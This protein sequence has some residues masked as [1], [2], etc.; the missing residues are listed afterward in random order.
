YDVIVEGERERQR[1]PDAL[2]NLYVRSDRSGELIPLSNLVQ[3][4]DFADSRSL[5]RYNRVRAITISAGLDEGLTLGAALEHLEGLAREHLPENVV[6][7]YKGQSL[8]YQTAGGSIVFIFALGLLVVFL[9]LAAQFESW[10]H[11]FVIILGVPFA[12]GGG[13]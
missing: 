8:D 6:I 2:E 7:D 11:P 4:E 3:L 9:V 5:S 13:L 1:S 12:V 10:V